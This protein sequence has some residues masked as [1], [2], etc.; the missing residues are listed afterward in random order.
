MR[1]EWDPVPE[2]AHYYL[3]YRNTTSD[4]NGAVALYGWQIETYLDDEDS[5]PGVVHYYWVK[6]STT[7]DWNGIESGRSYSHRGW[8]GIAAPGGVTASDGEYADYVEVRWEAVPGADWFRVY[9]SAHS[10]PNTARPAPDSNWQSGLDWYDRDFYDA[11]TVPGQNYYYFVQAST[12]SSGFPA[13]EL[14]AGVRGWRMLTPPRCIYAS[15]GSYTDFVWVNWCAPAAGNYLYEVRRGTVNDPNWASPLGPPY[16]QAESYL[17]DETAEPNVVYY[18]WVEAYAVGSGDHLSGLSQSNAGRR[19]VDCNGN[20]I[21]DPYDHAPFK[22]VISQAPASQSRCIG[23]PTTFTVTATSYLTPA[24]QWRRD[25]EPLADSNSPAFTIPWTDPADIG[26]YDVVV[27]NGCGSTTS[28]SATLAVLMPIAI[29]E[30]PD[31]VPVAVQIGETVGFNVTATGE[32]PLSYQW[33]HGTV[34]VSDNARIS[35]ATTAALTISNVQPDDAGAYDVIVTN[36]CG[37]VISLTGEFYIEL[38]PFP[39][40]G[41]LGLVSTYEVVGAGDGGSW[42]WRIDSATGSFASLSATDVPGVTGTGLEVAEALAASINASSGPAGSISAEARDVA[43]TVT[44]AIRSNAEAPLVLY[45]GPG[46][47]ADCRVELPLPACSFNPLIQ[48]LPLPGRDCNRNG[49]DDLVDLLSGTSLD[50]NHDGI[51]DEC[52]VGDV[53]CDGL[54]SFADINAFVAALE[55]QAFYEARYPGCRWMNADV[56]GDGVVSYADINPFVRRLTGQ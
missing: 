39:G 40:P 15:D 46:S 42:S 35:G 31:S 50:V 23:A 44:L 6:A 11:A 3:V 52:A 47:T 8:R 25:G 55:G 51:P 37:S 19:A 7:N 14:S 22:P 33:R 30:Q 38:P 49:Q 13:S 41:P 54:V 45:V 29:V 17:S 21:P 36:V 20:H 5:D 53:N 9:R 4:P 12:N 43:G 18:Y 32:T 56:N 10:D 24:Y 27:T 1:I 34:P 16:W 28:T 48:Q 26:T 2:P